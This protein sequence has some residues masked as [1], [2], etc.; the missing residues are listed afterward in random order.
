MKF[1]KRIPIYIATL[2]ALIN[3]LESIAAGPPP[4]GGPPAPILTGIIL[5]GPA[6]VDEQTTTQYTCTG[7]YSDSTTATIDATWEIT[8][9]NA[10]IDSGGLLSVGNISSDLDVIITASVGGYSQTW[11]VVLKSV[12][13]VLTGITIL[14]PSTVDEATSAQYACS[15]SYSDGTT[16][17]VVPSW[18]VLSSSAGIDTAGKLTA[19]AVDSDETCIY[20]LL[21][22]VSKRIQHA[23]QDNDDTVAGV[24]GFAN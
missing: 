13:P 20:P 3:P 12:A 18:T 1:Y 14:G 6:V 9:A 19:E 21:R 16:L 4:P 17:S 2:L 8:T 22:L 11:D 7:K 15:A 23:S 24:G 10:S 5:S